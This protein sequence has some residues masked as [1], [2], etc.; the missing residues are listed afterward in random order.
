MD[1]STKKKYFPLAS[2]QFI[3]LN[4]GRISADV[5]RGCPVISAYSLLG[6]LDIDAL[7]RSFG[8][9][10]ERHDALRLRIEFIDGIPRQTISSPEDFRVEIIDLTGWKN[11]HEVAKSLIEVRAARC[12]DVINR[13]LFGVRILKVS[14]DQSIIELMVDHLIADGWSGNIMFRELSFFY[15]NLVKQ[16]NINELYW[17]TQFSEYIVWQQEWFSREESKKHINYERIAVAATKLIGPSDALTAP[18]SQKWYGGSICNLSSLQLKTLN[19]FA[20]N[21]GMSLSFLLSTIY[22]YTLSRW[23]ESEEFVIYS[24]FNG[25]RHSRFSNTF[26]CFAYQIPLKISLKKNIGF[27]AALKI[28]PKSIMNGY[29]HHGAMGQALLEL[30]ACCIFAFQGEIESGLTLGGLTFQEFYPRFSSPV[31]AS[32]PRFNVLTSFRA[33]AQADNMN[34]SLRTN[35]LSEEALTPLVRCVREL[36]TEI[37]CETLDLT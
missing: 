4:L 19:K 5:S 10:V 23:S 27:D 11:A 12:E 8:F 28:V 7:V 15:N 18:P 3:Y 33:T 30:P 2:Q 29:L 9:F 37:V 17:P 31:F 13:S 32:N 34:I 14:L 22:A 20:S 36:I 35:M 25:R 26:G 24:T 16:E 6:D 21:C 1:S